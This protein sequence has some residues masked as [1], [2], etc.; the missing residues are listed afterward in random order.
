MDPRLA[1]VAHRAVHVANLDEDHVDD[2][3]RTVLARCGEVATWWRGAEAVEEADR[4]RLVQLTLVF[5]TVDSV[6][7]ALHLKGLNFMGR[8]LLI[9][10]AN[11]AEPP[12]QLLAIA[13]PAGAA[14][15]AEREAAAA[16]KARDYAPVDE[17]RIRRVA[18]LVR[19]M[20][21]AALRRETEQAGALLPAAELTDEDRR[22]FLTQHAVRQ[23]RALAVLTADHIQK[24]RVEMAA[25]RLRLTQLAGRVVPPSERESDTEDEPAQDAKPAPAAK[26][27]RV[28]AVTGA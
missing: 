8:P 22:N 1:G 6:S 24:R 27:H 16:K 26:K 5:K 13:G 20:H 12:K 2:L 28:E 19:G 21:D 4:T 15:A 25:L 10:L 9:W 17:E 7:S 18:D 11:S 3:M 14:A 23:A